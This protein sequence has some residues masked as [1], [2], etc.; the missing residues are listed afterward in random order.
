MVS[1]LMELVEKWEDP[2][3]TLGFILLTGWIIWTGNNITKFLIFLITT[4]AFFLFFFRFPDVANHV[5]LIIIVNFSL[6]VGIFST[7]F[8]YRRLEN[9][10]NEYFD[11]I[12]PFL[13]LTLIAVYF[14]AGFH[15]FNS[16]FF[17]PNV[18]CAGTFM[19]S[20]IVKMLKSST[21]GIPNIILIPTLIIV[22]FFRLL[23]KNMVIQGLAGLQQL[24]LSLRGK[25]LLIV[26]L[27]C[28]GILG[29][30]AISD[31][32]I[33]KKLIFV[34]LAVIV[35]IWELSGPI[36][37]FP[38]LQAP[39][40]LF[41]WSMHASFALIGFVDFSS[42]AFCLIFSFVP[43]AYMNVLA[44]SANIKVLSLNL[45]RLHAYFLIL[46][47][48]GLLLGV[49][50]H[51]FPISGAHTIH[52]IAFN[53]ACL[54]VAWPILTTLLQRKSTP[55]WRGVKVLNERSPKFLLI[56]I[57]VMAL[58]AMT[59]YLGLRTAGNFSMFSNLRTE[60]KTSN[61]LILRNNP[62]KIWG[63][64]EDIV[65]FIEIDDETA[66]IGYQYMALQGDKLPVVEFRKLI[67]QWKQENYTVPMVF[68]YQGKLYRTKDITE[69]PEW[70]VDQWDLEMRLMDFRKIQSLGPN[71]CRW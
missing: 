22:L 26:A 14:F 50:N 4:T 33:L 39:F 64:Q 45:N 15:K 13:R 6:I 43:T 49:H 25:F 8:Q 51:I 55:V 52:G 62:V 9:L 42:L 48:S 53:I 5:N 31:L 66:K 59:S 58:H 56:F 65:E 69:E 21:L 71:S 24:F 37:F 67:F 36:L 70:Q 20:G 11:A 17:N 46:I 18:S 1:I 40:L 28:L 19:S 3:I 54:V 30:V 68:R 57:L 38:V 35:V 2:L 10:N 32:E 34:S 29:Y 47:V 27:G 7:Y 44:D 41:S 61:H 12:A 23:P 63:Y 16:D 60:G